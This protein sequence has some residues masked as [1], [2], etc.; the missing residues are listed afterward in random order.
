MVKSFKKIFWL[1][2]VLLIILTSI[3]AFVA[4]H[5]LYGIPT[6]Y[7]SVIYNGVEYKYENHLKSNVFFV[8][9]NETIEEKYIISKNA[10]GYIDDEQHYTEIFISSEDENSL[11]L[12]VKSKIG[13]NYD[14]YCRTDVIYKNFAFKSDDVNMIELINIDKGKDIFVLD[15]IYK[16]EFVDNLASFSSFNDYDYITDSP[17]TIYVIT[18][19]YASVPFKAE[20]GTVVVGDDEEIF[21]C[22]EYS[23]NETTPLV[24]IK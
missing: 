5:F 23:V 9:D 4:V 6:L 24:R 12:I 21:L 15:D 11:F 17:N 22:D 16:S 10:E 2:A 7:D 3:L 13:R 8:F 19:S 20:I 14:V 1:V 18:C